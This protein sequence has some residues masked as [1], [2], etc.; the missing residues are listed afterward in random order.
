M[1]PASHEDIAL[2]L[3][4]ESPDRAR[5]Q[6]RDIAARLARPGSYTPEQAQSA[7]RARNALIKELLRS[8]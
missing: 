7:T 1:T 4:Q 5:F 2:Q 8:C 6:V 3:V